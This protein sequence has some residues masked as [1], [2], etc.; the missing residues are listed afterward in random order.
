MN[1]SILSTCVK[2][3]VFC[4]QDLKGIWRRMQVLHLVTSHT[5]QVNVINLIL[6]VKMVEQINWIY[7]YTFSGNTII[8]ILQMVFLL[9]IKLH[10]LL[11]I[12]PSW[13]NYI[14]RLSRF[15][16]SKIKFRLFKIPHLLHILKLLLENVFNRLETANSY[17]VLSSFTYFGSAFIG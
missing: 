11:Y 12:S 8:L 7:W 9:I 3:L 15:I 1:R 5:N 10:Q 6:T 14:A 16:L 4:Q 17:V 13:K 2:S